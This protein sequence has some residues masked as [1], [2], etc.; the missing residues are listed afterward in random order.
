MSFAYETLAGL[1]S[2]AKKIEAE[3]DLPRHRAL[4]LAARHGGFGGYIEAKRKLPDKRR[5]PSRITIRQDWWG[6]ESKDGGTA[7]IGL[8]LHTPLLKLIRP[9]HLTGYFGAC[10]LRSPE[11][12]E[13]SGQQRHAD[14][15]QW[16]IGRIARA[17]Q[18][19]DATGLK[20]SDA[21]RRY[22]GGDWD[23][24][25][26]VADHDHSWYDPDTRMHLLSTEPYPGRS[27]QNAKAQAKWESR[28]GWATFFVN[29]G[30]IYGNGTELILCCPQAHVETLKRIVAQL[31]ASQPAVNDSDVVI[32]RYPSVSE[33]RSQVA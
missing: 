17:L 2:L 21:R 8:D 26:P 11:I 13:R 9:H 16:Y 18:F 28:H 31:E 24:R 30:G 27:E 3:Q 10:R 14:E 15:T 1:K 23:C 5:P 32:T 12:I 7:E 29:W 33:L 22:P 25:P 4:D 20:P 6:Y 19:M